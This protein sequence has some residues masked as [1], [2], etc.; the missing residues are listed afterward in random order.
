M[1]IRRKHIESVIHMTTEDYGDAGFVAYR[2]PAS[3]DAP[4]V[5]MISSESWFNLLKCLHETREE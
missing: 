4:V 1:T 3:L 2:R 5:E